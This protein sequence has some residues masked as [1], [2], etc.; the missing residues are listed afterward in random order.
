MYNPNSGFP[1]EI[2]GLASGPGV[3]KASAFPTFSVAVMASVRTACIFFVSLHLHS[4]HTHWPEVQARCP[5]G[6]GRGERRVFR[7]ETLGFY[8][9]AG[10]GRGISR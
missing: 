1:T 4:C 6:G 9:S 7:D 2:W 5:G 8:E 3:G 10:P